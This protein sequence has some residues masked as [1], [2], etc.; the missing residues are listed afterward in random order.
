M[1]RIF[2]KFF[3]MLVIFKAFIIF[4]SEIKATVC[5]YSNQE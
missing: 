5:L 4:S 3:N 2:L 1:L